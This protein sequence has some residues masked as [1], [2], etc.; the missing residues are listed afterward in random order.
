M[1]R[2]GSLACAVCSVAVPV[3]VSAQSGAM[4]APAKVRQ[5][6]DSLAKEYVTLASAPGTAVAVVRGSDTLLFRGYGMAN[7][8]LGTPVT[9][10]SV[11]RIGSVTKQFTASAVLQLVEQGKISLTDS[12]GQWV[13]D[14]P[15][16]WRGAT[17]TQLLNHT[18]GIPSYTNV[19]EAWVKRWGEEMT[20]PQLVALVADKPLDFPRGTAWK[21]DNTGYVLLGMLLEARTGH[22]WGQDFA[23]R[24]FTPLGMSR[25]RYCATNVL[26]PDRA[27]GYSKNGAGPWTNSTYLAMSQPHA[28]GAL[29]STIGDLLTWNRALH[30]GRILKPSSYDAMTTPQGA[31]LERKY[32]FALGRETLGTHTVLTHG[33]RINGFLTGNIF[34]PD[35]QL[36]VTVLTNSDEGGPDRLVLQLARAALGLPLEVPPK[37][38]AT[39]AAA[40]A[41]YA[42][43]YDLVIGTPR[44]FTV[45]L[46]AGALFGQLEGQGPTDMIPLGNDTFGAS[47][48]PN[49]RIVFTMVNGKPTKMTLK[50]GGGTFE[51]VRR[52]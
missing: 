38:V 28:G 27:S 14:L 44:P 48:D 11:F 16:A 15:I 50:Q 42:G 49:L 25:T 30:N 7:L 13:P 37:A 17:V 39:T 12:I 34:I 40:L 46:K 9:V 8:E 3:L 47:F 51:G 18:S 43:T 22:S 31:A 4:P 6:L 24:F 1:N 20:G 33:G 36:S 23:E 29:C 35:A 41:A 5:T 21:Y 45:A 10:N 26:I 32:G 19:G 52:P 2:I